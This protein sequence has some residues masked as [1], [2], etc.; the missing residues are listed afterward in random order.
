[1]CLH[2][3]LLC[4]SRQTAAAEEDVSY[5][6]ESEEMVEIAKRAFGY[7]LTEDQQTCLDEILDDMQ[8]N[9]PMLRILQ[10]DVGTGKTIIALIAMFA[11]YGSGPAPDAL[12]T[13]HD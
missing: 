8:G 7:T 3:L 9:S 5:S 1:M 12:N 6:V 13:S 2:A 11:T 10:G 4:K